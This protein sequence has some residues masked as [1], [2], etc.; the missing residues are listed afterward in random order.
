MP[1]TLA[2]TVRL[3]LRSL[4]NPP[5][6]VLFVCTHGDRAQVA[7]QIFNACADPARAMAF[8]VA[9]DGELRRDADVMVV[10]STGGRGTP[11]TF[12]ERELWPLLDPMHTEGVAP[13]DLHERMR[14][15][16]ADLIARRRWN[17]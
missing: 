6:I 12:R 13:Q 14:Q 5:A 9:H 4:A 17:A 10:L 2:A 16:V 7:A 3:P 1:S 15:H 8:G 11:A